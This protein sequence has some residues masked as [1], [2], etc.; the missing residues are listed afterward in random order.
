[1]QAQGAA[2]KERVFDAFWKRTDAAARR[3]LQLE[4][5]ASL[6]ADGGWRDFF[7]HVCVISVRCVCVPWRVA[8]V[9]A[10][11]ELEKSECAL[12]CVR[13]CVL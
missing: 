12:P 3:E 8:G 5:V 1:M 9:F 6:T 4:R 7:A 2:D 10:K 13:V 11:L